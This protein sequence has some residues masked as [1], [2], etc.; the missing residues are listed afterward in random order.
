MLKNSIYMK[1]IL[2][3]A[4]VSIVTILTLSYLLFNLM[5]E[6]IIDRELETQRHAMEQI[7]QYLEYQQEVVDALMQNIYR[8]SLLLITSVTC[9]NIASKSICHFILIRCI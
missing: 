4:A 5:S 7:S 6:S 8:N 3:F 9:Y 1:M 2:F